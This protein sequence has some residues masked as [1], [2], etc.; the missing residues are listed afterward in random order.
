MSAYV[1]NLSFQPNSDEFWTEEVV[2]TPPPPPPQPPPP[3][4]S[5]P[6]KSPPRLVFI[7]FNKAQ[8]DK[9]RP[10]DA[11]FVIKKTHFVA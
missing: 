10:S 8:T 6:Q 5:K 7:E 1:P 11:C 4:L 3:P 2:L 9:S